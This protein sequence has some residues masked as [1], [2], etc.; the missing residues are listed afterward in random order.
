MDFGFTPEQEALR[1]EVRAFIAEHVTPEVVA[2]SEG[3]NEGLLGVTPL[4]S[5]GPA[6]QKLFN[7]IEARGWLGISYPKE[8]GGQG[9][10][11]ITQY[12][13]EEEFARANVNVS[14]A[15]SSAPAILGAGTEE[16]KRYFIPKLLRGSSRLHKA[17]PSR[18]VAPTSRRCNAGPCATETTMSSTARRYSPPGRIPA[19]TFI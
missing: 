14:T 9:G 19:P 1:Q 6:V 15:G 11:R 3:H 5:R 12:I 4:T 18:G 10:D 16:Q 13:V 8:Y 2:E 7:K 17:S